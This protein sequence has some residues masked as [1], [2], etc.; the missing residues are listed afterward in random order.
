MIQ[1][2]TSQRPVLFLVIA[3]KISKLCCKFSILGNT[4]MN[5]EDIGWDVMDWISVTQ[6][7]DQWRDLKNGAMNFRVPLNAGRP[8]LWSS[9]QSSWLQI[10]R[11]GFDSWR[12]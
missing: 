12:Y 10:R 8:P 9:G 5:P 1:S 11:S 3:L 7:M 6:D 4:M 2:A